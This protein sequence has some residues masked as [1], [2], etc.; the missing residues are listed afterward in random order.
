M[1]IQADLGPPVLPPLPLQPPLKPPSLTVR[2]SRG[3]D[4]D[5]NHNNSNNGSR[6]LPQSQQ[7]R[8]QEKQQQQL[9]EHQIN[10]RSNHHRQHVNQ[11]RHP[12][13]YNPYPSIALSSF[14]RQQRPT[15]ANTRQGRAPIIPSPSTPTGTGVSTTLVNNSLRKDAPLPQ[16]PVSPTQTSPTKA[17][18]TKT[19][20]HP[21]QQQHPQYQQ[22]QQQQQSPR[23]GTNT[24]NTPPTPTAATAVATVVKKPSQKA[25]VRVRPPPPA[26]RRIRYHQHHAHRASAR[27]E[28]T[29]LTSGP[30]NNSLLQMTSETLM[31]TWPQKCVLA[32]SKARYLASEPSVA[33]Q[34]FRSYYED[35]DDWRSVGDRDRT[36]HNEMTAAAVPMSGLPSP[37]PEQ[38]N[39]RFDF[40]IQNDGGNGHAATAAAAVEHHYHQYHQHNQLGIGRGDA[41]EVSSLSSEDNMTGLPPTTN[42]GGEVSPFSSSTNPSPKPLTPPEP[43][44][45]RKLHQRSPSVPRP[46]PT[47]SLIS[48]LTVGAAVFRIDVRSQRPTIL[49]LKKRTAA[50]PATIGPASGPPRPGS[51]AGPPPPSWELPSGRVEDGDYCISDAIARCVKRQTS[52]DVVRIS[53]MLRETTATTTT[54]PNAAAESRRRDR[55]NVDYDPLRALARGAAFTSAEKGGLAGGSVRFL[56]EEGWPDLTSPQKEKMQLQLNWTVLVANVDDVVLQGVEHEEFIWANWNVLDMLNLSSATREVAKEALEW[57]G[58]C[59]F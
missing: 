4:I 27:S 12:V 31:L 23:K 1:A 9:E 52:L 13:L 49:L 35:R 55:Q 38:E 30:L 58:R 40:G 42:G 54:N 8:L 43:L 16:I 20:R 3:T 17:S 34:V 32:M 36:D 46:P 59:S 50:A 45:Q 47:S 26:R 11:Q 29:S 7:S 28:L 48:H 18:P 10:H 44:Q 5:N 53:S 56:D 39:Y 14:N 6:S 15:A 2:S 22:Q 51:L 21:K 33:R 57:A 41:G 25:V 37:P 19:S 24:P